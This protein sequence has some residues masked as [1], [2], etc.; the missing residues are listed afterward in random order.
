M[1]RFRLK[2]FAVSG[3]VTALGI[4]IGLFG[5]HGSGR[6]QQQT[7]KGKG[8]APTPVPLLLQNYSPVTAERLKNPPD[9]DWLMIRAARITAGV[10]AI[11][12]K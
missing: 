6:A 4:M 7:E 8:A 5:A 9:A 12:I 11:S 10:I 1:L 3:F 2:R